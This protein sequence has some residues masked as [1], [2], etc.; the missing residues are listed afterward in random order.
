[1]S[2]HR[3]SSSDG[4]P[5]REGESHSRGSV[6]AM[7]PRLLGVRGK[8]I[9][10]WWSS[11]IITAFSPVLVWLLSKP[12]MEGLVDHLHVG[13]NLRIRSCLGTIWLERLGKD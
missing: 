13:G 7:Y 10:H 6:E 4:R 1:M 12:F 9:F 3:I 2:E 11:H 8:S 5:D